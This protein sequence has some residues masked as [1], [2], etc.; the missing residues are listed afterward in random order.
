[1]KNLIITTAT[2]LLMAGGMFAQK[3]QFPVNINNHDNEISIEWNTANET[4]SSYFLVE[5]S[6]DGLNFT[7]ISQV[8]AAGYSLTAKKY[9]IGVRDNNKPTYYRVTEVGMGGERHSSL[10]VNTISP[11]G[12]LAR[13]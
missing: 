6:V 11:N 12:S 8:K 7:T 9:E 5:G 1:M 3:K 2:I 13:N 10:V 4:N